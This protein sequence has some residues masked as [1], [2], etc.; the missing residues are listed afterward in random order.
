MATG[1]HIL[2]IEMARWGPSSMCEATQKRTRTDSTMT[3]SHI[4]VILHPFMEDLLS[5]ECPLVKSPGR[6]HQL[7]IMPVTTTTYQGS[8]VNKTARRSLEGLW[9]DS[10]ETGW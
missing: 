9:V 4:A 6:R 7:E 1:P 8:A 10:R 3:K 2:G 5:P